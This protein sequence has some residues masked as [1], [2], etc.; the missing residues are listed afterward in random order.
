VNKEKKTAARKGQAG[1]KKSIVQEYIE[2]IL[3]AVVLALVIRA[4]LV[5]AFRIPSRSMEDT[6]LVGD[7]LLADKITYGAKIPFTDYR[8][9]GLRDPRPGDIIIFQYPRDPKRDFIKRCVAVGGQTVE[10]RDKAL[11]VDDQRIPDPPRSKHLRSEI[12]PRGMGPRDNYGPF[13]IPPGALFMMGDNRDD[14]S[15]SR[16]WGALPMKYVKGKA[17]VIYW[18]WGED[19][20]APRFRSILSVPK[21]LA[22]NL[23]HFPW[24]VRW[25]RIGDI[26]R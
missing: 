10:V 20:N 18:S 26:I 19:E 14:S 15:D 22:Y 23:I 24:R 16:Y 11:Y 17:L 8:L 2:A 7:F 25:L 13:K 21:I 6:L 1:R 9:P 12:R 4:L 5:Q 3:V